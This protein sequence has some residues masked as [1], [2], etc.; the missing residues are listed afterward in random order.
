MAVRR[1]R[2]GANWCALPSDGRRPPPPPPAAS[3]P[4]QVARRD[5]EAGTRDADRRDRLPVHQHRRSDRDETLLELAGAR[6]V[7]TASDVVE[8]DSQGMRVGDRAFGDR[9]EPSAQH[10]LAR[11]RVAARE[12]HLAA[13]AC[14][15]RAAAPDPARHHHRLRRRHL[16][17]VDHVEAVED[18]EVRGLRRRGRELLEL[19]PGVADHGQPS[20][21]G[22][23]ES[24][25]AGAESVTLGERSS[26]STMPSRGERAQEAGRPSTGARRARERLRDPETVRRAAQERRAPSTTRSAGRR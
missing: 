16:V 17:D 22:R 3:E 14:V 13:G 7:A 8:H 10:G 6:R 15:R 24:D 12:H 26:R 23:S 19:R 11:S 21:R 4:G 1:D 20:H 9:L 25:D 5:P 2:P 18:R